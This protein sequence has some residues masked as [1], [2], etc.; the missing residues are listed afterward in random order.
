MV[1]LTWADVW[2]C[3]SQGTWTLIWPGLTYTRFPG[4]LMP[5]E[6]TS[7]LTFT[8]SST[9]GSGDVVALSPFAL[10]RRS[11]STRPEPKI[12]TYD[13]GVTPPR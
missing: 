2:P 7:K 8:P 3:N 9:I 11:A 4:T 1:T 5:A 10:L 13:P 6:G 12:E